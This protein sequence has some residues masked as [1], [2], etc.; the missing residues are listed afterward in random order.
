MSRPDEL[1]MSTAVKLAACMPLAT[2]MEA[3]KSKASGPNK[4]R[5]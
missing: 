1:E 5:G 2:A 3:L 4:I